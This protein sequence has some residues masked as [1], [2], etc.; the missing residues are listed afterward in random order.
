LYPLIDASSVPGTAERLAV[1]KGGTRGGAFPQFTNPRFIVPAQPFGA[2]A[3]IR[4]EL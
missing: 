4:A 2:W 1:Y 3:G